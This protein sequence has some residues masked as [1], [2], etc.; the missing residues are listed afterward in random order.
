MA[1]GPYGCKESD[2]TWRQSNS[3]HITILDQRGALLAVR[4]KSVDSLSSVSLT[5]PAKQRPRLLCVIPVGFEGQV[6][7]MQI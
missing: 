1:Y 2:T 4:Y 5:S 3:N 6:K 7:A